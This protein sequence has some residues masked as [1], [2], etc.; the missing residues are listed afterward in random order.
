MLATLRSVAR[1]RRWAL[2]TPR[3]LHHDL[4][5][6][7]GQAVHDAEKRRA[8]EAVVEEYAQRPVR[9]ILLHELARF[10]DLPKPIPTEPL[11]E[12]AGVILNDLLVRVARRVS[13]LRALPLMVMLNPYIASIYD[14]YFTT[15]EALREA[16]APTTREENAQFVEMLQ[17]MV[18]LHSDT[19]PQLAQ[20]FSECTRLMDAETINSL[21]GRLLTARIGSRLLAEHHIMLTH[22]V[23][24]NFEGCIQ[25]DLCPAEMLVRCSRI[26]AEM[27]FLQ[28]GMEPSV[29]IDIGADVKMAYVPS[30]LH[31]ILT[32]LLKNAFRSLC[33]SDRADIPVGATVVPTSQ[34]VILRLRDRG[35]G[36]VPSQ[37]QD[38]F[39]FSY[40]TV[41]RLP[42]DEVGGAAIPASATLAG[43]GYGLPLSR[44][45]AEFFGGR[46]QL[47][48]CYGWGT[49]VYLTLL[50]PMSPSY[51]REV[52]E[53]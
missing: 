2:R 33:E 25:L 23:G 42:E 44:A 4:S 8:V 14:S 50:S 28:Y 30:H 1:Y 36:I 46:L 41:H 10:R 15:F 9:P 38:V 35:G 17:R 52:A 22:P 18:D 5:R 3:R 12:N 24:D 45:Y 29:Q 26:V 40:T 39:K 37:L 49:D 7:A 53:S 13:M 34:G 20:G 21:L 27:C 31:Y 32:E 6:A 43:L 48:S 11:L 19:I 47:Q 16:R 51:Y